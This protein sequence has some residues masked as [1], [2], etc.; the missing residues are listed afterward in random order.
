MATP[1]IIRYFIDAAHRGGSSAALTAAAL[2]FLG[3]ALAKQVVTSAAAYL[4]QDVGW[5]ATNLLRADLA[6]HCLRLDM[7]FHN[8]RTP[9]EMIERIDGDVTAI[10]TFF[11]QFLLTIVGSALLLLGALALL[12]REDWRVGL[13]ISAFALAAAAV[14]AGTRRIA[15]SLPARLPPGQRR[16]VRLPGGAPGRPGRPARQRGRGLRDGRPAPARP[17]PVLQGSARREHAH[18]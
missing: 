16:P 17:R 13:A 18:R 2:L 8:R 3:G 15:V 12:W 1:Q 4:G 9:G 7:G 14:L 11:S 10:S 6:E 5:T